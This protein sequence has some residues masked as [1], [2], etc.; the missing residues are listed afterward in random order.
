MNNH[1]KTSEHNLINKD[2]NSLSKD[3]KGHVLNTIE[4]IDKILNTENENSNEWIVEF[5]QESIPNSSQTF[6]SKWNECISKAL[7][8]QHIKGFNTTSYITKNKLVSHVTNLPFAVQKD[9][10]EIK[11]PKK[12]ID[13]NI[14]EK[15][16]N[17]YDKKKTDLY[18]KNGFLYIKKT[19][20]SNPINEILYEVTKESI[21]TMKWNEFMRWTEKQ[22]WIRPV[23]RI[24]SLLNGMPLL[25]YF[26]EFEITTSQSF[27]YNLKEKTEFHANSFKDYLQKLAKKNIFL[28][29]SEKV[30]KVE[31]EISKI[32]N[33]SSASCNH[34]ASNESNLCNSD[35]KDSNKPNEEFCIQD[36]KTKYYSKEDLEYI[37]EEAESIFVHKAQSPK[38]NLP[39]QIIY[40]VIKGNMHIPLFEKSKVS[41]MNINVDQNSD[42]KNLCKENNDTQINDN[43]LN[44]QNNIKKVH[45]AELKKGYKLHSEFIVVSEKECNKFIISQKTKSLAARLNDMEF[46]WEKDCSTSVESYLKKLAQT[47]FFDSL[48]SLGQKQERVSNS[49]AYVMKI[50]EKQIE[51]I[52]SN[53]KLNL[54]TILLGDSEYKT[55]LK[56]S[57]LYQ[58]ELC[59]GCLDEI[60]GLRGHLSEIFFSQ[61]E[62]IN[63]N[64]NENITNQKND[65][66]PLEIKNSNHDINIE[67]VGKII[68]NSILTK[69]E[70]NLE[71]AILGFIDRLDTIIGFIGK[72][73]TPT[74]SS[75]PLGIR[76]KALELVDLGFYLNQELICKISNEKSELVNKFPDLHALIDFLS[77][78]Y[79]N[80]GIT[81]H[82]TKDVIPFIEKRIEY[83]NTKEFNKLNNVSKL[84]HKSDYFWNSKNKLNEIDLFN[85]NGKLS[86]VVSIYKR[87]NNINLTKSEKPNKFENYKTVNIEIP[88]NLA[89]FSSYPSLLHLLKSELNL[90]NLYHISKEVEE[91]FENVFISEDKNV[92][93][94]LGLCIDKLEAYCNFGKL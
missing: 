43:N 53:T 91:I 76:R 60:N 87:L 46:F 86:E 44:L 19:Y 75:D 64:N 73:F 14:V 6:L 69:S 70:Q 27:L 3:S 12:E 33:A 81:L 40:E 55:L 92:Q 34:N 84:I 89:D 47:T 16:L 94:I 68:K 71:S 63:C 17:K 31:S 22:P 72:G 48:G 13:K 80:Q 25:W 77:N 4:N 67:T 9:S 20:E 90:E 10:E 29:L 38:T 39:D 54:S 28:T 36:Y 45:S 42:Q 23:R 51:K 62:K 79:E 59:M 93:K 50:L 37:S 7:V 52:N 30:E 85:K 11:G 83:L 35:S 65:N 66:E 18:E 5:S 8:S 82:K 74:G 88:E 21:K 61:H 26:N 49:I 24:V 41:E 57:E 78:E 15:F 2:S 56:A 32:A 58:V 1:N